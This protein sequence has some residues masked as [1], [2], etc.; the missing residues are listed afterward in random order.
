MK[1]S[2]NREEGIPKIGKESKGEQATFSVTA[3]RST[4]RKNAC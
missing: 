3:H 4:G 1:P 2:V